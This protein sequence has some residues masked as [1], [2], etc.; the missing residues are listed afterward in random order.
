MAYDNFSPSALLAYPE[1]EKLATPVRLTPETIEKLKITIQGYTFLNMGATLVCPEC[2]KISG[3]KA[4]R[5]LDNQ[6]D[7]FLIFGCEHYKNDKD[8]TKE[9]KAAIEAPDEDSDDEPLEG[10]V[11]DP[12]QHNPQE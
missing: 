10:T 8:L 11:E 5:A 12:Q 2:G 6:V 9:E 4:T 1:S 3:F 7:Y